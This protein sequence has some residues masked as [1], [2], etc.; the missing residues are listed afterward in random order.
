MLPWSVIPIAGCPS[1][2]AAA[3]TSL[4]RAAPSSI[5]NSVCRCKCE[6]ESLP[7]PATNRP[8][9]E[10]VHRAVDEL[11]GCDSEGSA[12]GRACHALSEIRAR[13]LLVGLGPGGQAPALELLELRPR[14]DLL[15]EQGRLDAVEQPLEPAD[16]LRLRHPELGL[17][18]RLLLEREAELGQLLPQLGREAF[19][20]LLD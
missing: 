17:G 2:L 6:K 19:G 1:A 14:R 11:Q 12:V 18:G 16:Q 9:D 15:G 3:M 8:P 10:V 4:T 7:A 20:Q 13:P 5:E